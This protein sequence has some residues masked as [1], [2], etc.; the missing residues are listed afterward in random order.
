MTDGLETRLVV[1]T[2]MMFIT[3]AKI[4]QSYLWHKEKNENRA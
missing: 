1:Q 3:G 4:I 2:A